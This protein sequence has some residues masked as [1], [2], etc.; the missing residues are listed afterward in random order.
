MKK[1]LGFVLLLGSFI[2]SSILAYRYHDAVAGLVDQGSTAAILI[3]LLIEI[4]G[5]LVAPINTVIF[6]PFAVAAWG[7]LGA[8]ALSLVGWTIG[9]LLAYEL[10]R[11][12]GQLLLT[13][14]ASLRK[15]EESAHLLPESNLFWS[16]VLLRVLVPADLVSYAL[17][18]FTPMRRGPYALATLLGYIPSALVYSYG[19]TIS[20]VYQVVLALLLFALLSAGYRHY[21]RLAEES[22]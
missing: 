16:V 9:S 6:T 11:H 8:A 1:F 15:I 14:F 12:Y 7:P 20:P 17:G 19:S 22:R 4:M 21:L 10:A 2:A 3:F 13:R 5:V 18:L